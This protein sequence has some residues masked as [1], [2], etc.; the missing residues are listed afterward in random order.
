MVLALDAATS[1]VVVGL[2]ELGGSVDVVA[3][4]RAEGPARHSETLTPAIR[5]ALG[6]AGVPPGALGAVVVGVGP[7]PFTGLRVGL[8]TAAAVGD[9]LD[10]PVYGV[11][12]L[13]GIALGL[14]PGEVGTLVVTD[15]RRR[16]VYWA[17]Y[18]R[19]G[20]RIDGPH[21]Q[22]PQELALVLPELGGGR[23]V[24]PGAVGY[25]EALGLSEVEGALP[26]AAGLVRAAGPL[27]LAGTPPAPLLP[28]YLRRPDAVEPAARRPAA[29]RP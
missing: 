3:E 14:P 1:S 11:C 10:V 19:D 27:L 17:A 4:I 21:V 13:D 18:D 28:M 29:G 20:R 15:A 5:S 6:G 12:S 24:G 25:A 22:R 9:A 26:T 7:G 8:V 23:V 16:E 2:V